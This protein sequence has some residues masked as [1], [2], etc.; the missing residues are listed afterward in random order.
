[1]I[2]TSKARYFPL[3]VKIKKQREVFSIDGKMQISV[4]ANAKAGTRVDL[5]AMLGLLV[6]TFNTTVSKRSEIEKRHLRR[7]SSFSTEH[8]S[9][10]TLPMEEL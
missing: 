4:E 3:I 7:R 1:M 2:I 8:K 6:L 5:A 9:L 10:K